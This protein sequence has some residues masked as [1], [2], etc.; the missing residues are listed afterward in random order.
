MGEWITVFGASSNRCCMRHTGVYSAC[1]LLAA[2]FIT[3]IFA[4]SLYVEFVD[5]GNCGLKYF[6]FLTH[7]SLMLQVVYAWLSWYTTRQANAM[8]EERI[9]KR[10]RMPWYAV[11][12]WVLQDILLPLTFFVFMLYFVVVLP[13]EERTPMLVSYFTHGANFATMVLDVFLSRQPYYIL[14]GFYFAFFAAIY[15]AFSYFYFRQGGTD[16]R[17]NPYIYAALDWSDLV[18]TGNL[19]GLG[20]FV[21]IPVVNLMFW[22]V[23]S[24]C[25]PSR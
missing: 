18:K 3:A 15:A 13:T 6:I 1:E 23:I 14:H 25:F 17:G 19:V 21:I 24:R 4:W 2:L 8:R 10:D 9:K 20:I 11:L 12:T 7:W 16:C 5:P 22:F